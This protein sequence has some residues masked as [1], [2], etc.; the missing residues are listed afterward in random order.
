[1]RRLNRNLCIPIYDRLNIMALVLVISIQCAHRGAIGSCSGWIVSH[2]EVIQFDGLSANRR[3]RADDTPSV[4]ERVGRYTAKWRVSES[5]D[6]A[7]PRG[8]SASWSNSADNVP[9]TRQTGLLP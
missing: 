5:C 2:S 7:E 9:T 6:P 1:M 8:Y 3:L 4:K